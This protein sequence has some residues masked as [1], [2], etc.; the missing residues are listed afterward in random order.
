MTDFTTNALLVKASKYPTTNA[1]PRHT[2]EGMQ[3][4]RMAGDAHNIVG[5][6][7]MVARKEAHMKLAQ[8]HR[9]VALAFK[10]SG[11]PDLALLNTHA[12]ELHEHAADENS[13]TDGLNARGATQQAVDATADANSAV[14]VND[15]PVEGVTWGNSIASAPVAKGDVVGHPFHGNQYQAGS[16][17][18]GNWGDKNNTPKALSGIT[19]KDY[20]RDWNDAPMTDTAAKIMEAERRHRDAYPYTPLKPYMSNLENTTEAIPKWLVQSATSEDL[21]ALTDNNLFT[22]VRYIKS[23]RPDLASFTSS[24]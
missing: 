20:A 8:E 7:D 16:G 4:A 2:A 15:T 18:A 1:L 19:A 12:A 23:Q 9:D 17:G 5:K 22:A 6:H 10:A 3:L 21:E 24:L 13:G 11:H 14:A